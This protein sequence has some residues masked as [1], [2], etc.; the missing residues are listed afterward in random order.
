MF[1]SLR[2]LCYFILLYRLKNRHWHIEF[3]STIFLILYANQIW[4]TKWE[5]LQVCITKH[6]S[7]RVACRYVL[8]CRKLLSSWNCLVTSCTYYAIIDFT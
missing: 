5:M 7:S 6:P 1:F 8:L 3:C 4:Y 2:L